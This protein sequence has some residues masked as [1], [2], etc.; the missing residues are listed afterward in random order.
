M[1]VGNLFWIVPDVEL[2]RSFYDVL[3]GQ[4][5]QR[6][7]QRLAYQLGS[8]ALHFYVLDE[9]QARQ[10][11]L[12]RN[13]PD[14]PPRQGIKLVASGWET[15]LD[16]LEQAGGSWPVPWSR[17]PWGGWMAQ[18]QDPFGYRWELASPIPKRGS[19]SPA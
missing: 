2:A 17:S 6:T 9:E 16:E 19:S 12:G 5:G 10:Y 11:A 14:E 7:P 3:F 18:L 13:T 1:R 8:L 15:R 4:P